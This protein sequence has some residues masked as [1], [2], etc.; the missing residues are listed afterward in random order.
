MSISRAL[1]LVDLTKSSQWLG[2]SCTNFSMSRMK[3]FSNNKLRNI[4]WCSRDSNSNSSFSC[5]SSSKW[6]WAQTQINSYSLGLLLFLILISYRVTSF[7]IRDLFQFLWALKDKTLKFRWI[8]W[9]NIKI[10]NLHRLCQGTISNLRWEITLV[11]NSL[12]NISKEVDR[13]RL[14]LV[15][16]SSFKVL[17]HPSYCMLSRCSLSNRWC[18]SKSHR[19]MYCHPSK[20]Y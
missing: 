8:K 6:W 14:V 20:L 16:A 10:R 19:N 9:C 2:N 15:E 5:N 18:I 7:Q 11:F 12:L 4:W 3:W 17:Y 1:C 13:L